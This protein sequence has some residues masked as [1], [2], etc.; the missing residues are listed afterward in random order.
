[1]I[2]RVNLALA[3]ER[4]FLYYRIWLWNQTALVKC[5]MYVV[6]GCGCWACPDYSTILNDLQHTC[7]SILTSPAFGRW[8]F[9]SNIFH[10]PQRLF[11][12]EGQLSFKVLYFSQ[13]LCQLCLYC[14]DKHITLFW[15]SY[16]TKIK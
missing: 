8:L 14:L 4:V 6:C 13:I 5:M 12:L 3:C 15:K 16:H 11:H 2:N 1:M 10:T 9:L 7:Q